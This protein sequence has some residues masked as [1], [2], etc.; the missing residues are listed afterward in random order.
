MNKHRYI[1]AN[2]YKLIR[3]ILIPPLVFV[4]SNCASGSGTDGVQVLKTEDLSSSGPYFVGSLSKH[5]IYDNE[6]NREFNITI[7]YPAETS[8]NAESAPPL[9]GIFPLIIN[10]HGARSSAEL[11]SDR[12]GHLA[13]H[14][15]VVIAPDFP[16]TNL[17]AKVY[18]ANDAVN[19]PGD[20]SFIIDTAT[21]LNSQL[22]HRFSQIIDPDRIG[23]SGLS[24]G[25]ITAL[26]TSF[27][28][29][30]KDDRIKGVAVMA[31]AGGDFLLPSFYDNAELPFMVIHGTVDGWIDYKTVGNTVYEN[32]NSPSYFLTIEGG[33]HTGYTSFLSDGMGEL[34][35]ENIDAISCY[36]AGSL[37]L[38]N[39]IE[40][41]TFFASLLARGV[42]YGMGDFFSPFPCSYGA[43]KLP[44]IPPLDQISIT[45]LGMLSFFKSIF[46]DNETERASYKTYLQST[47]EVENKEVMMQSK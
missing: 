28:L 32:S 22:E 33:T 31:P 10:A 24:G 7:W 43:E 13:S 17:N 6:R 41:D 44:G 18:D 19:Q 30:Y 8:D 23:L 35:I 45:K 14:G 46:S 34:P 16:N 36:L 1:S 3:L 2:V 9:D 11:S 47:I 40:E 20:I 25:G 4:L 15:Y 21:G 26:L 39:I 5:K 37:L 29:D 38:D 27:D 12:L 42:D